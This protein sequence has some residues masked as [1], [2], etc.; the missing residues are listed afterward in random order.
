MNSIEPTAVL[1]VDTF[2]AFVVV[3]LIT[4][5]LVALEASITRGAMSP[6]SSETQVY[7]D[8]AEW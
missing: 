6:L 7:G 5:D 2:F 4:L 8:P 3:V 1:A